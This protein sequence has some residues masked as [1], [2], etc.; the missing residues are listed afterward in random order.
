MSESMRVG[1]LAFEV[2][3]SSRRRTMEISVER[4]GELVLRAPEG[5]ASSLLRDFVRDK[6]GWIY[7]K[8]AEKEALLQPVAR[9]EFVSGEGFPYLGRSYR[10]LL[11][12]RQDVPLKL[13]HGRFRL[14][15]MEAPQGSRHFIDWYTTRGR[16]WLRPRVDR[17]A[18]R[19]GVAPNGIDVRDLG[20]RWGSCGKSGTLNFHWATIT[21][22]ASIV[23]YVVVHELAHLHEKNHTP[24]FWL[25]VERAMPDYERRKAWLAEHG[26][27]FVGL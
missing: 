18:P 9:K 11:V 7:S 6:R 27:R 13:D 16:A 21:L 14:V 12:N 15:R 10:L 23:E 20:Y 22:P 25:R 19:L 17:F 24:D 2:R 8:L 4:N 1:D 5:T 26:G 3:W